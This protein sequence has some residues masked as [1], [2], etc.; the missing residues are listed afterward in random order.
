MAVS[1]DD[2]DYHNGLQTDLRP[3]GKPVEVPTI[4]IILIEA[5]KQGLQSNAFPLVFPSLNG[6]ERSSAW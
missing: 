2:S 5:A 3:V 6:S 4:L 1:N